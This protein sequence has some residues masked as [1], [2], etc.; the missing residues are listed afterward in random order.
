MRVAVF[1]DTLQEW[2]FGLGFSNHESPCT[3]GNVDNLREVSFLL[4]KI[5]FGI[6]VVTHKEVETI[7]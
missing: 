4:G 5:S 7:S 2:M 1:M 6:M 3:G